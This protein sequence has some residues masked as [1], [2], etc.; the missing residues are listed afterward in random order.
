MRANSMSDVVNRQLANAL[1]SANPLIDSSIESIEILRYSKLAPN[2]LK[3][4]FRQFEEFFWYSSLMRMALPARQQAK[5]GLFNCSGRGSLD[6]KEPQFRSC[7]IAEIANIAVDN[8]IECHV[9]CPRST[10]GT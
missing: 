4:A 3:P 6:F 2:C 1:D 10:D 5:R 7:L 9:R 8:L